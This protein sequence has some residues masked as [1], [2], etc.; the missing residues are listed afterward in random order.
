ML[1][2]ARIIA[3][4]FTVSLLFGCTNISDEESSN[5]LSNAEMA[6]TS[7]DSNTT[8]DNSEAESSE[9][10]TIQLN[11]QAEETE[12]AAE[13]AAEAATDAGNFSASEGIDPVL[14][15]A[16]DRLLAETGL[17]IEQY[18]F[19]FEESE[20]YIQIIIREKQEDD[21]AHAPLVG[22]YRYIPE[23]SEILAQD[24]LTGAFI[25][26]DEIEE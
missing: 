8:T 18:T 4:V 14:T 17:D 13:D 22:T 7:V 10:K 21:Q 20:E 1:R 12:S 11:N 25:P 5:D 2:R 23:T 9:S 6:E 15:T 26:I 3:A 16:V 19:I 24:Y